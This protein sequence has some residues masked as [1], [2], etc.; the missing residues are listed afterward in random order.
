[1]QP[2]LLVTTLALLNTIA[3]T[4]ALDLGKIGVKSGKGGGKTFNFASAPAE[5]SAEF[6]HTSS[7]K[8]L[9]N[10]KKVAIVNFLVEFTTVREAKVM[11]SR[12]GKQS[13]SWASFSLPEP[14]VARYQQIADGSTI[15]RW[16]I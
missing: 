16:R 5:Q 8:S 9:K 13:T 12:P 2:K 11:S 6:I 14:D 3:S 10:I 4:P 15:A 1:M 7:E